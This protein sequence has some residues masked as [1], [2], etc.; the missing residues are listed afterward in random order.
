[1]SRG[2]LFSWTQCTIWG[3][4]S[5]WPHSLGITCSRSVQ[6]SQ[7]G[8]GHHNTAEG[9]HR[10]GNRPELETFG[11]IRCSGYGSHNH[12]KMMED[13]MKLAA[14]CDSSQLTSARRSI[15]HKTDIWIPVSWQ[16][17]TIRPTTTTTYNDFLLY[18]RKNFNITPSNSRQI[19]DKQWHLLTPTN[20]SNTPT[21]YVVGVAYRKVNIPLDRR[22]RT[23]RRCRWMNNNNE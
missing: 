20:N 5:I 15:I 4:G 9:W 8:V 7:N 12:Y 23:I 3:G 13:M 19:L 22:F 18:T 1:M 6:W 14:S 11:W 10:N 17:S 21:L 2:L 16:Q